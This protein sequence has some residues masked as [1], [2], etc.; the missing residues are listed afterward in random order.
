MITEA[1]VGVGIRGLE[2]QQASRSADYAIGEFKLLQRLMFFHGRECYRKNSNLILYCLYKNVLLNMP[3]FWFGMTHF[4]SGTK[5]YEEV[6][7]QLFNLAYTSLPIG[8]YALFDK[9]C[10]DT[11]L[12]KNPMYYRAGI[13]RAFF[14]SV[15]FLEWFLWASIVGLLIIVLAYSLMDEKF[16]AY[17]GTTYGLASF[18]E[19][20]FTMVIIAATL[21]LVSF[22]SSYSL[23]FMILVIGSI[24]LGFITWYIVNTFDLGLLEHTFGKIFRSEEYYILL[25]C[26]LAIIAFDWAVTKIYDYTW[27]RRYY[28]PSNDRELQIEVEKAP[29]T[30]FVKQTAYIPMRPRSNTQNFVERAKG[31]HSKKRRHDPTKLDEGVDDMINKDIAGLIALE[32]SNVSSNSDDG[33]VSEFSVP[34]RLD[35][36][37]E[38]YGQ[39]NNASWQQQQAQNIQIPSYLEPKQSV[40]QQGYYNNM[41]PQFSQFTF[42]NSITR[43]QPPQQPQQMNNFY[44]PRQFVQQP[45]QANFF[46]QIQISQ[47]FGGYSQLVQSQQP[48]PAYAISSGY[49]IPS[50]PTPN[51]FYS[52]NPLP[53]NNNSYYQYRQL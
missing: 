14:N 43:S 32:L 9:Q 17:E 6:G 41:Q 29:D 27:Y 35:R 11:V 48:Q 38:N 10:T 37:N 28:P 31:K 8:I 3:N 19:C 13:K 46:P 20:A 7:Y 39:T 53:Q 1:H 40:P 16:S 18:G 24:S 23:I 21:K 36:A 22:T 34:R 12:L 30:E 47:P 50:Q 44:Q 45:S 4:F 42:Q 33:T 15:R 2:G 5:L 49:A 51:P 26:M 25:F 52:S